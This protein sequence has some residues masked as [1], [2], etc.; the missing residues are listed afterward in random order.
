MGPR[1]NQRQMVR[2]LNEDQVSSP[3]GFHPEA[4]SELY[5]SLSTNTAPAMEACRT[6][7]RQ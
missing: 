4:L 3:G 1:S 5:V 2:P 7:I 6:P